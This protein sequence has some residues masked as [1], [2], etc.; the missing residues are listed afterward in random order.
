MKRTTIAGIILGGTLGLAFGVG[1]YTL[2]TY[3]NRLTEAPI[4]AP[5]A[6]RG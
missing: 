5:P 6:A 1:A 3:A 4:D 2:S